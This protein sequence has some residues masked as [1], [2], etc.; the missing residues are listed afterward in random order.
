MPKLYCP[1]PAESHTRVLMK[2]TIILFL[3]L[4]SFNAVSAPESF[5]IISTEFGVEDQHQAKT[6]CLTVLRSP[7]NGHL[8]G[9]VEDIYDCF[10]A[11]KAANQKSQNF[12]LD[13]K[14]LKSLPSPALHSYLQTQDTQLKFYF[15]EGD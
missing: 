2:N 4:I 1:S 14:K 5:D 15:S 13:L 9:I 12:K 6:L 10:I 3:T 11:R 8:Y 7:Q